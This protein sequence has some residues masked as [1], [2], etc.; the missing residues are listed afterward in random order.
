MTAMLPV[1][2]GTEPQPTSVPAHGPADRGGNTDSSGQ[3]RRPA[4][5]GEA[6]SG[7]G[8]M[9]RTRLV[10]QGYVH[11]RF[12]GIPVLVG[13]NLAAQLKAPREKRS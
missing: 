2:A 10:E 7:G 12:G 8:G 11:A 1:T 4:G 9:L 5:D 6:T 13:P 3:T